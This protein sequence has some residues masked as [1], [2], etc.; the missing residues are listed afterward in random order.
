M[1]KIIHIFHITSRIG[2]AG[3]AV[4][5]LGMPDTIPDM[6]AFLQ[7]KLAEVPAEFRDHIVFNVDYDAEAG[8]FLQA[9]YRRPETDEERIAREQAEANRLA[10]TSAKTEER[11]RRDLARLKL[12]YEGQD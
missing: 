12:K 8:A 7:Q 11:E 4:G 2:Y 1:H 3:H 9:Y 5:N 6:I 10:A